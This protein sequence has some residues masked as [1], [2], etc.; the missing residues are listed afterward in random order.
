MEAK[1]FWKILGAIVA[2]WL[3][4]AIVSSVLKALVPLV[5]IALVV[6]GIVTVVKWLGSGSKTGIGR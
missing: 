5:V 2:V 6:I 1:M 3:I 4:L